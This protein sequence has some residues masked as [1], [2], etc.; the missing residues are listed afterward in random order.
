MSRTLETLHAIS[1][2]HSFLLAVDPTDPTDEGFL[3]GTLHGREFWRGFRHGGEAGARAFQQYCAKHSEEMN[4]VA[5]T[6]ASH[7]KSV[8][9]ELYDAVRQ[10]LRYAFIISFSLLIRQR[11]VSG[12]RN[13]EMRWTNH[14]RLSAYGVTLHGWPT[15]IPAQNPS[16]LKVGQNKQLLQLL[17]DGTLY[18]SKNCIP[19]PESTALLEPPPELESLSW[20][21]YDQEDALLVPKVHCL[22]F[23][24]IKAFYSKFQDASE[25]RRRKR[26][27]EEG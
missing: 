5:E 7:A 23:K 6:S 9:A 11:S 27:R 12:V 21:I 19:A 3:G 8:K 25:E 22:P 24:M 16:S 26:A 20:A 15:D 14:N 4:D 2:I 10:S 13:A 1:G 18:F 17:K